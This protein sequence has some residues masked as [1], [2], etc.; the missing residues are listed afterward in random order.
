MESLIKHIISEQLSKIVAIQSQKQ[1]W[2][3]ELLT[4]EDKVLFD[5]LILLKRNELLDWLQWNNYNGNYSD[6]D[7]IKKGIP[8]FT[9]MQAVAM[10][11]HQIMY[12]QE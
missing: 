7:C 3:Y 6:Q 10:V 1:D 12:D 9:K 2:R 11:Y 4:M 8:L 5:K